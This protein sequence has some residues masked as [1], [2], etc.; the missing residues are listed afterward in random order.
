MS[1]MKNIILPCI[2]LLHPISKA[3]L[4]NE[5]KSNHLDYVVVRVHSTVTEQFISN[6]I[7]FTFINII[8]LQCCN[9]YLKSLSILFNPDVLILINNIKMDIETSYT[10]IYN[11]LLD[12]YKAV[13]WVQKYLK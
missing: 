13:L 1:N 9:S 6:N 4:V 10:N 7:L 11:Y 8:F 3:H 5:C 2:N 12:I